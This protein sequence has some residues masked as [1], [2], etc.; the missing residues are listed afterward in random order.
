VVE[1]P[2]TGPHAGDPVLGAGGRDLVRAHGP[3]G[4]GDVSHAVP[5]RV[6]NVVP[7]RQEAVRREAHSF[8]AGHP[9]PA[10]GTRAGRSRTSAEQTRRLWMKAL[11]AKATPRDFVDHWRGCASPTRG[12][13]VPGQDEVNVKVIALSCTQKREPSLTDALLSAMEE[14]LRETCPRAEITRIRLIDY[15]I[16]MCEGEDTCLDPDVGLCT[17]E[18]DFATVIDLTAG[19]TGMI[20]AMP[21]YGGSMPAVLKVFQERL[22]SFMNDPARPLSG[23][24]VCTL[25]HARTMMVESAIGSLSPWYSRLKMSNVV[26][27]GLTGASSGAGQDPHGHA[28]CVAAGRQFGLTLIS[29]QLAPSGPGLAS[30]S[31]ARPRPSCSRGRGSLTDEERRGTT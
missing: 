28:L 19:A 10:S 14:G 18:D 27:L 17:I 9:S 24:S 30:G 4:F 20:L 8:E 6:V 3:P 7:E 26:T 23:M 5:P 11:E 12:S 16:Q 2:Q 13:A 15:D 29:S 22:K 1:Q 31:A 25:A 21:V